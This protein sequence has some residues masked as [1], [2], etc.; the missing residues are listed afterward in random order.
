MD[1]QLSFLTYVGAFALIAGDVMQA[2]PGRGHPVLVPT[3]NFTTT[4]GFI[5]LFIGND[6]MWKRAVEVLDVPEL[7]AQR[8]A[9]IAGRQADKWAPAADRAQ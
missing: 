7:R 9:T 8:F 2:V 1:T 5:A 3:E 4:D 6:A